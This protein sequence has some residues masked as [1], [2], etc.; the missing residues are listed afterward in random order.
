MCRFIFM[1][2]GRLLLRLY[3][4]LFI[5]SFFVLHIS[6]HSPCFGFMQGLMSFCTIGYIYLYIYIL[7]LLCTFS[8]VGMFLF[9][10]SFCTRVLQA[11]VYMLALAPLE[12]SASV[13]TRRAGPFFQDSSPVF[14]RLRFA[15]LSFAQATTWRCWQ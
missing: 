5:C 14:M 11:H 8:H 10:H 15:L 9:V 1:Y 7:V 3:A 12:H 2:T 4:C 13:S 6:V